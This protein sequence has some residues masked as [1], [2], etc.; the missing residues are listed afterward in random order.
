MGRGFFEGTAKEWVVAAALSTAAGGL[1]GSQTNI[2]PNAYDKDI[3]K[4]SYRMNELSS[5]TAFEDSRMRGAGGG[6]AGLLIALTA[7]AIAKI[8]TA[9]KSEDNH[10]C[11]GAE[12]EEEALA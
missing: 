6:A 11:T 9:E 10:E 5:H 7:L 12:I 4:P 2:P 3:S 1:A 8:T